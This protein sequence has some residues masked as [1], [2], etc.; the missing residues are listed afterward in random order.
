M[1]KIIVMVGSVTSTST[2]DLSG[3]DISLECSSRIQHK[4]LLQSS[5]G[6][7]VMDSKQITL[8]S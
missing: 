4:F 7:T 8:H 5:S 6:S 2:E 3:R 1:I